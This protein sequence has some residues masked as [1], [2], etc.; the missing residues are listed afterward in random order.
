MK[1][2]INIVLIIALIMPYFRFLT[3]FATSN[4]Y[5]VQSI[6]DDGTITDIGTYS[7]YGEAKKAMNNYKSTIT[8]TAVIK[9]NGKIVSAAYGIFRPDASLSTL[10]VSSDYGSRYFSPAYN[11]DTLFL[12]YNPDNN[13]VQIMIS[14][15]KAWVNVDN[16][17]VYPIS[18]ISDGDNTYDQNKKYVKINSQSV[19]RL[20]EGPGTNYQHIG[21]ANALSCAKEDLTSMW[22]D[23]GSIYEWLNYG[24]V[25]NDGTYNWYQINVDGTI[26]Y[27]ASLISS[28]YLEEYLVTNNKQEYRTYYYV[29]GEGELYHQYYIAASGGVWST[30]LGKA[31]LYLKQNIKY[32]SFDGN[33]FYDDFTKLVKDMQNNTYVNA[34]NKMPYYNYYQYLPTRTQ[35]SYNADNLNAYIGYESK[36]DRSKYYE[37]KEVDGKYKWVAQEWWKNSSETSFPKGQ[38]MLYNEGQ[39]FITSQEKYGVNASQTLSLAI[40]ESGWGRSYMSVREY[41]IFGHGAFD[42]APDEYAAS[43]Q[44]ISD[45]IM[46]H[47]FKYIAKDYANPISGLHYNGSHYGNK[48]S[49]N[50]VSYASDAYWGE[51]MAGNYYTL[52]KSFSFQDFNQRKTLGMKQTSVSAP[53]YSNPTTSSTKYYNLKNVPN[54]PVTILDEIEGEEID[55]NNI[56]YKIQS[57]L[58]IDENRNLVDINL[59]TYNFDTSYAYIHSSYIYKESLEPIISAENKSISSGS[60]F[61]PLKDVTAYDAFDGDVTNKIVVLKNE[62]NTKVV[63][64]YNVTYEVTDS[65][66]NKGTKTIQINVLPSNPIINANDITINARGILNP[67]NNVT[68]FDYEDG[69]LTSK[70]TITGNN[71]DVKTPG[72]YFITYSVTDKDNNVTNKTVKVTVLPKELELKDAIFYLEYLKSVDGKLQ[73]K[74]FN[75]I[76]GINNTLEEDIEYE[77]IFTNIDTNQTI[78]QTATR[79]TDKKEFTRPVFGLDDKDYT[80]SWFKLDINLKDLPDGNYQMQIVSMSREYKSTSII[81]NKLY[82]TQDMYFNG[83][84]SVITRNNFDD[85]RGPIELIVRSEKLANKTS[86]PVY[87]QY[88]TFRVLEFTDAGLHLKGVS[89]SYGM[90]L[91]SNKDVTREII[92]ENI[93]DYKLTYRY[94]LDST[95]D[96]LYKVVLPVDDSLNKDRAW[97]DKTVDI[98]NIP[99]GRYVIYI[100][101]SSNITDIS[102]FTEKLNRDISNIT[103]TKDNKKYRFEINQ[104]RGNRIELIVENV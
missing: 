78:T 53:V 16:G 94:K 48:L 5:V 62:V 28:P 86:S 68:A 41:N 36:I 25:V 4:E 69:D 67:L 97:Y 27:V 95:L 29:N 26:G 45:G 84:K 35:T 65:E 70:I 104:N 66:N 87:N 93:S 102:E 38:S 39:A 12:D 75:T 11:S 22:A 51:K 50:N 9:R 83:D 85:K 13:K 18:Y 71:V 40:T 88:D 10:T 63:G 43:Y 89:Y 77:V 96:G 99:V 42:S 91:S 81:S 57:D 101:T 33:Y 64:T 14:G 34:V 31:P 92:F 15:V 100:T 7:N 76:N 19:L 2:I 8:D 1:K 58:P 72:E 3:V 56:W 98:T 23:G 74:G 46:A 79:I 82:T 44:T 24:Q 47:A 80:Y 90:D 60:T 61:N 17:I 55:G 54:V 21:C 52:D 49:G 103:Y 32:Y 59:G 30:R 20:R 73:I 6:K 37:L